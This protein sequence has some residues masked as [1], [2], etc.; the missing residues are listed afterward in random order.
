MSKRF[1]F[2]RGLGRR[3]IF[4]TGAASLGLVSNIPPARAAGEGVVVACPELPEARTAELEARARATLLTSEVAANAS[5][6]CAGDAVVIQVEAGDDG[7]TINLRVRAATLREEVL[8]ALDRALADLRSRVTPDAQVEAPPSV[9]STGAEST[10]AVVDPGTH[11]APPPSSPAPAA[12]APSSVPAPSKREMELAADLIGESWGKHA[13]LGG[14]IEAGLNFDSPW[15]FGIRAGAFYPLGLGELTAFEG[16]ALAEVAFTA[17]ALAGLRFGVGAGPSLLFVAPSSG[18]SASGSTLKSAV[19]VEV[20]LSRPFRFS[21][22]AVVP[23]LGLR[24]FS[25][26]RGVRVAE[27]P[28]LVLGGVQPQLGVAFSF[29]Q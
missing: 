20:Q 27:Q 29:T 4:L 25:G 16:H 3:V 28:R 9:V 6:S 5:I 19:R 12:P 17:N 1:A 26:E 24:F 11:D 2:Q 14:G 21:R 23:W 22:L 10:E 13:A 15:A 7:V 18:L 8:R